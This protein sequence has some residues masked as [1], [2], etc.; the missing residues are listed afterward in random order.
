MSVLSNP[1][2]TL[3]L[4]GPEWGAAKASGLLIDGDQ[5]N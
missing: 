1:C 4:D 5:Q 3:D 2:G